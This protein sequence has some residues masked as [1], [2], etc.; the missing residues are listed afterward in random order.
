MLIRKAENAEESNHIKS[1]YCIT[2]YHRCLLKDVSEEAKR[3]N[4]LIWTVQTEERSASNRIKDRKGKKAGWLSFG[5]FFALTIWIPSVFEKAF[6]ECQSDICYNNNCSFIQD[7][8]L[9]IECTVEDNVGSI[10]LADRN[11]RSIYNTIYY[12]D[13]LKAIDLLSLPCLKSRHAVISKLRSN[14]DYFLQV[15]FLCCHIG[16]TRKLQAF[17]KNCLRRII[18]ICWLCTISNKEVSPT[19]AIW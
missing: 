7:R 9:T 2:V 13:S 12:L 1:I 3:V 4:M 6:N 5:F 14:W 19:Q 18:G 10:A 16:V 8:N 15:F 11:L 17:V